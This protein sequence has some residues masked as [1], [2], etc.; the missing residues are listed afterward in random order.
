MSI[1]AMD[2]IKRKKIKHLNMMHY[3]MYVWFT[4]FYFS[5]TIISN[6]FIHKYISKLLQMF[7]IIV[8]SVFVEFNVNHNV[9]AACSALF[10]SSFERLVEKPNTSQILRGG[11]HKA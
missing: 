8:A 1:V 2:M 11:I 3:P 4:S 10:S 7:K 6:V 9:I 5:I